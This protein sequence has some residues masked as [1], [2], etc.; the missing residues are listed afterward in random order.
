M[1]NTNSVNDL[2]NS[3]STVFGTDRSWNDP[4]AL[5]DYKVTSSTTTGTKLN[6][7][8]GFPSSTPPS[9]NVSSM[10]PE[11]SKLNDAGAKSTTEG[12]NLSAH[13]LQKI[14]NFGY[15]SIIT[16]YHYFHTGINVPPPPI[17]KDMAQL[18]V[19]E[20]NNSQINEQTTESITIEDV[21][22]PLEKSIIDAESSGKIDKKRASDIRKRIKMF[23]E[24][25]NNGQLNDRLQSGMFK[26]TQ[27]LIKN[28]FQEAEKLQQRLNI[29][30]PSLCTPWMIAIRQLILALKPEK[31]E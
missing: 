9:S 23:E 22:Q 2:E 18:N 24:K 12:K 27:H 29:D 15:I 7:R 31:Q 4:Q 11:S 21:T 1:E 16:Y 14:E 19:K 13:S 8:I 25:W 10:R 28:E 3:T 6:K 26:L 5:F 17:A 20:S 30:F